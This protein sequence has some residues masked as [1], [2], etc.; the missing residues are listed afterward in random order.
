MEICPL[1]AGLDYARGVVPTP[2]G[3]VR[4]DWERV[5]EDQLAVRVDLPSG[6]AGRFISPLGQEH[7]L[8][9]GMQEF[10]T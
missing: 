9:P 8:R 3:P 7:D 6:T 2:L 10:H 5:G 1:I 4:V